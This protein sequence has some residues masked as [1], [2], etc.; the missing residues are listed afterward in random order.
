M[1]STMTTLLAIEGLVVSIGPDSLVI[2]VHASEIPTT[3]EVPFTELVSLSVRD[4]IQP[5]AARTIATGL[6]PPGEQFWIEIEMQDRPWQLGPLADTDAVRLAFA[7]HAWLDGLR[8]LGP[9]EVTEQELLANPSQWH[10]RRICVTG[11]WHCGFERS[12]FANVWLAAT[13][14][15]AVPAGVYRVRVVGMWVFPATGEGFGHLGFWPGELRAESV[16]I[17]S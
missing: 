5:D 10:M 16:E 14:A 12:K 4:K 8:D 13:G 2:E 9:T 7:F 3:T 11:T 17:L 15:S 1:L 6:A